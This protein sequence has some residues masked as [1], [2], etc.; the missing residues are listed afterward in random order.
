MSYARQEP[1][2]IREH[3]GLPPAFLV[4]PCCSSFSLDRCLCVPNVASV[5]GLSIFFISPSVSLTFINGPKTTLFI[6]R[7]IVLKFSFWK[8]KFIQGKLKWWLVPITDP[9]FLIIEWTLFPL[10][11]SSIS[12]IFAD[13]KMF[14][15]KSLKISREVI[16]ICKWM[17]DRQ[18][19]GGKKREIKTI[20]KTLRTKL[21][22]E[23]HEPN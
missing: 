14:M 2:P 22:I 16:R 5:S 17:K 9:L 18:H 19:N 12:I 13:G 23:Q 15:L 6:I 4:G 1:I 8:I 7:V 21:K 20:Y 3:L 10:C 11:T